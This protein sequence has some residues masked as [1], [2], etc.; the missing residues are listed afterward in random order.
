VPE[1]PEV[2]TVRRGLEPRVVGRRFRAVD[3]RDGRLTAPADPAALA[4][5]LLGERVEAMGRRGKYLVFVLEGGRCLIAH[6][7]MTG[8]F[9]H[10]ARRPVLAGRPHLRAVFELDDGTWLLY[11]DQRRFGT[12]RLVEPAHLDEFWRRRVGPEPLSAEWSAAGFRRAI[13]TRRAPIKALLLAQDVVAGV[14]NIYA[15]EALWEARIHPLQ[16][17][18]T[19]SRPAATRLHAAVVAALTRGIAAQGAS[20]R[21]YRTVD[22]GSGS[23]Q[24]RFAVYDRAGLPCP[25]CGTPIEKI[26]VAQRG[27]HLCPRDQ[28]LRRARG[29]LR[30]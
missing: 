8:W 30:P 23:M 26:R 25:R 13:A 24:E 28:R 7:R 27:T 9:H 1:L 10:V 11:T 29:R 16:E 17:G 4:A 14:G 6:L 22:G 3:V 19:L 5:E 20:I 15:D 12:M 18:A 21:N 2:E